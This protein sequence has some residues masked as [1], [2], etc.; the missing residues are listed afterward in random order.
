MFRMEEIPER[1]LKVYKKAMSGKSKAAALKAKCLDCTCW[2]RKE[3][4][5]CTVKDCPLY[6]YRPYGAP[7]PPRRGHFGARSAKT[8]P[9]VGSGM[10]TLKKPLFLA[11]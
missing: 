4:E 5:N 3:I 6:P 7:N 11:K 2:Q 10:G 8:R 1:Y 9:A